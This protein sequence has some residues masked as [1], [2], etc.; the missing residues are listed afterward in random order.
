MVLLKRIANWVVLVGRSPKVRR[1]YK[2][3]VYSLLSYARFYWKTIY[4]CGNTV[5]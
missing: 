1:V 4:F 3:V 2:H 5:Q